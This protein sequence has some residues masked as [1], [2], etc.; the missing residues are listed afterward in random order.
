M[1]ILVSGATGY[2]GGRLVPRLLAAGHEVVCV[3]RNPSKLRNDVW[4][5]RV[6]VVEGD[7]LD[8]EGMTR[9]MTGCDAAFYLVHSMEE[10]DH[11]FSV[12]DREAALSFR[13]AAAEAGL[14]RIVYLGGLGSGANMSKHLASR[15]EVGRLLAGGPTPVTELRAAVIIGSGSVSFEMLRYLT[16]VLPVMITPSWVRTRCQPIAVADVLKILVAAVQDETDTSQVHEIG[17]PD[18]FSYVEMMRIYADVAGLT[19]RWIIPVPVLSP[20]LS[21]HW[22]GLVTPLPTGVAKPLVESLRTEVTVAD[23]TYAEGVGGGPLVG[24]REAVVQALARS[25]AF[26]VDSRWSEAGPAA[27]MSG[28]P[29]WAGGTVEVDERTVDC[30]ASADDLY[31]AF[32]RIGGEVGYYTMNWAW[33]VRGFLDYVAGGGGFRRGRRNPENIDVGESID[34]WRVADVAPGRKLTLQAEMKLPGRAWLSFESTPTAQGS[35]L[36]QTATFIPRGLLG[37]LYWW[38][39]VPFHLVI[40]GRMARRI[41][42]IAEGRPDRPSV[43]TEEQTVD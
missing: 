41:A 42:Q 27:V 8:T 5:S 22:V 12:R 33:R 10:G 38:I 23:N 9:A 30:A 6:E 29:A 1:R 11:D 39:L 21:S 40:F 7:V 20:R 43:G 18:R 15:Q 36:R 24:Y 17:G 13:S 28:D 26:D 3:S 4:R 14:R 31:W 35:E 34:F 37:R 16:E 19:R 25:L 32:A 2:I